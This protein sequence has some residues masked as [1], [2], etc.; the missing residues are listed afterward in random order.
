MEKTN[1]VGVIFILDIEIIGH[2]K[3][4]MIMGSWYNLLKSRYETV[5]NYNF[6]P[7]TSVRKL[8]FRFTILSSNWLICLLYVCL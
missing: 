6:K 2:L 4:S 1:K 8:N 5:F 7:V 3:V